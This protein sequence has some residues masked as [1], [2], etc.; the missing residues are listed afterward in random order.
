MAITWS[1]GTT[2]SRAVPPKRALKLM[3]SLPSCR[4][5]VASKLAFSTISL[6][7]TYSAGTCTEPSTYTAR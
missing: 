7:L 2:I 6:F 5:L 3:K 1:I 4:P